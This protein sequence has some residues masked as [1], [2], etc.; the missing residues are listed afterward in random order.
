MHSNYM[1]KFDKNANGLDA[2]GLMDIITILSDSAVT[3][4]VYNH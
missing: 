4:A 3:K 1:E 2:N